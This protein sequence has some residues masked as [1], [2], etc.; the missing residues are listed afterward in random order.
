MSVRPAWTRADARADDGPDEPSASSSSEPPAPRE[1]ALKT[2]S[3]TNSVKKRKKRP[4][5]DETRR[6][7]APGRGRGDGTRRSDVPKCYRYGNYDRYYGYRVGT[8]MEDERLAA[9]RDEWFRGRA[10]CDV[11]CNDGL[12]SLSLVSAYRPKTCV[13]VDIDGD[14]VRAGRRKLESLR[15]A[16]GRGGTVGD[17]DDPFAGVEFVEANAVEHDFGRERFDVVLA[18]SVTKWIHLNF[19]DD[20]VKAAFRRCRDALAPGGSFIL[21]P[22]PWKS[23][24]STLRKKYRGV[25]VLPP[26]CKE[27]YAA[28]TFRP[29][30]FEAYLLSPDGGFASCERL[31]AAGDARGFDRDLLRFIKHP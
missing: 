31:R 15:R 25:D 8:S 18:L 3:G 12:F 4:L 1:S 30:A 17:G 11:G 2:P 21:E 5:A 27:R 28:I 16:G 29:D 23:Y 22:Q 10:V 24:K 13:C 26:E 19:G 7:R 14:L 20:G 9:L 6:N